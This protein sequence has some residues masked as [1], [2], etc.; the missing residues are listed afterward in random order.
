VPTE[1]SGCHSFSPVP[2]AVPAV[3]VAAATDAP[4]PGPSDA[5]RGPFRARLPCSQATRRHALHIGTFVRTHDTDF[6]AP[7]AGPR[8]H[9][10]IRQRACLFHSTLGQECGRRSG[11]PDARRREIGPQ[12]LFCVASRKAGATFD[13]DPGRVR[14]PSRNTLRRRAKG[15]SS[16]PV[17]FRFPPHRRARS[18]FYL[19]LRTFQRIATAQVAIV[20]TTMKTGLWRILPR[21][22]IQ[23]LA[24]VIALP[25]CSRECPIL[26]Q[27]LGQ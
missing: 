22:I 2:Y 1:G 20:V 24:C 23:T 18:G 27:I 8:A 12:R 11:R 16:A 13:L 17:F 7:S 6:D 25:A 3:A 19:A 5:K 10:G 4:P 21:W 15:N 9:D 14:P 26:R